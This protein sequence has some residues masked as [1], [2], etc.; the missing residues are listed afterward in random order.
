MD[1]NNNPVIWLGADL[2]A[3]GVIMYYRGRMQVE[4]IRGAV[5]LD[6]LAGSPS[7]ADV[8]AADN[9]EVEIRIVRRVSSHRP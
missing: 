1:A 6:D 3:P 8:L 5:I 7:I 9:S 4:P 2:S